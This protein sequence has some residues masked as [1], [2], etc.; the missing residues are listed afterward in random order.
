MSKPAD[1]KF[2]LYIA[3][4]A[5][6][7]TQAVANL[8]ALCGEHLADRHEIE[9]VDVLSEPMR[10]LDDSIFLTPTLVKLSPNPTRKIIGSLSQRATVLQALGLPCLA[11]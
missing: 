4:N 7:S 1:Y 2:R 9:I 10:A 6:N 8:N 5:P 11:Q 3:G